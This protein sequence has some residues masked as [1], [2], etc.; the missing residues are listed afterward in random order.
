MNRHLNQ[1]DRLS[2]GR[3][4]EE[5]AVRFLKARHLKIIQRNF[6]CQAGELDI[7]ARYKDIFIFVEVRSTRDSLFHDPLDSVTSLKIK[8]L[9]ILAQ[10]WLKKQGI[11]NARLRFDIVG[12]IQKSGLVDSIKYI[13]DAF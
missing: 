7:I 10:I 3:A 11:N 6:S 2:L 13:E 1:T 4:S 5:I 8:R 12:I 9:R